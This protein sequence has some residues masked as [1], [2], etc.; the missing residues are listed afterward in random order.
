LDFDQAN[1]FSNVLDF[2][3]YLVEMSLLST[4]VSHLGLELLRIEKAWGGK[5]PKKGDCI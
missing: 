5:R 3:I 1:W 4:K 2:A